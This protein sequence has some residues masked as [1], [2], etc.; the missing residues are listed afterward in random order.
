MLIR[1]GAVDCYQQRMQHT[2]LCKHFETLF[3][4]EEMSDRHVCVQSGAVMPAEE[5]AEAIA[6][7]IARSRPPRE[8]V[9]GARARTAL[10]AGF[11]QKWLWPG[12]V[13]RKMSRMFGLDELRRVAQ[14]Q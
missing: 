8:I 7:A 9:T 10:L 6:A 3:L 5:A 4:R 1:V 13:E 14:K 2:V 12:V 11:L